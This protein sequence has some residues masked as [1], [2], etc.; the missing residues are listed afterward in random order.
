MKSTMNTLV[1][2]YIFKVGDVKKRQKRIDFYFHF[3]FIPA[4]L[5]YNLGSSTENGEG[6]F[7]LMLLIMNFP[8]MNFPSQ[9]KTRWQ[10]FQ[11]TSVALY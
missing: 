2:K 10:E 3:F 7:Q 5:S 8:S 6:K 9:E 11:K 4:L 1:Q